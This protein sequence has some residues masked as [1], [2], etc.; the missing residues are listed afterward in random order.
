M[1]CLP[2]TRPPMTVRPFPAPIAK[3]PQAPHYVVPGSHLLDPPYAWQAT[4]CPPWWV[5][6]FPTPRLPWPFESETRAPGT[7]L[8]TTPMC[9]PG[10]PTTTTMKAPQVVIPAPARRALPAPRR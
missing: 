3:P 7:G 8:I 6:N 1:W 9:P 4:G 5:G 10:L 2:R